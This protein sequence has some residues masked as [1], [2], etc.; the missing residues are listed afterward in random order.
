MTYL[1]E[2]LPIGVAMEKCVEE[3]EAVMD[4]LSG[5]LH[6]WFQTWTAAGYFRG[7]EIAS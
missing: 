3:D 2:G 4:E 1:C 6:A 5:S 7:I